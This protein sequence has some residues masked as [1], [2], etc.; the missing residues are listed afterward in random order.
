VALSKKAKF[1]ITQ[2]GSKPN[3]EAT[4]ALL[5]TADDIPGNNWKMLDERSWRAGTIGPITAWG[6]RTRAAKNI[7]GWRSFEQQNSERWIWIQVVPYVSAE[8]ARSALAGFHLVDGLPN[9]RAEVR[10]VSELALEGVLVE[11]VD[12]VRVHIQITSGPRGESEARYLYFAVDTFVAIWAFS[13]F[14][15]AWDESEM[16]S[17]VTLQASR[18]KTAELP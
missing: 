13:S 14:G 5:L 7:V 2:I 11:G 17:L 15:I 12:A 6:K 4:L 18:L 9:S 10:V 8:D 16:F 1:A 3:A